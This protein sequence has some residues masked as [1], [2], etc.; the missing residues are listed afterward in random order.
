MGTAMPIS[1]S[2]IKEGRVALQTYTDP[3]T[4]HDLEA[5]NNT[6]REDILAS[7][8]GKVHVVADFRLM[9]SPPIFMLARGAAQLDRSHPN[10]GVIV[11]ILENSVIYRLGVM[12]VNLAPK[13]DVRLARSLAEGMRIIDDI[14]Q[15]EQDGVSSSNEGA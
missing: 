10:T 12:F 15:Q 2:L 7:A 5:L 3:L 13:H 11:G 9:H 8:A 1:V 6:M 14:L 4:M